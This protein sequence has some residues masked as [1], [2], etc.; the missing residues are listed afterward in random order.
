MIQHVKDYWL[1]VVLFGGTMAWYGYLFVWWA[2]LPLAVVTWAMAM[3]LC[4]LAAN[5]RWR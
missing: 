3:G 4:M 1:A 5:G 2:A